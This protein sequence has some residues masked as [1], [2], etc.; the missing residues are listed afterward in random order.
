MK[1]N[2]CCWR[3][4]RGRTNLYSERRGRI[5]SWALVRSPI[6]GRRSGSLK[7][8][9]K[10]LPRHGPVPAQGWAWIRTTEN[11]TPRPPY[12]ADNKQVSA[13]GGGAK[14]W[15]ETLSVVQAPREAEGREETWR[16]IFLAPQPPPLAHGKPS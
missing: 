7:K 14:E 4:G 2:T 3:K 10:L 5:P 16:K 8:K 9:K 1:E 13:T 6:I 15:G 12:S 11:P